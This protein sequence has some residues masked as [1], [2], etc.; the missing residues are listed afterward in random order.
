M[1]TLEDIKVT[2]II[3]TYHDWPRLQLCLDGLS[4]QTYPMSRFEIIV[5]NNDPQEKPPKPLRIPENCRIIEEKKPGSYSARNSGLKIARGEIFAFTDSDCIPDDQWI[6]TAVRY[7]EKH[8]MCDRIGGK[9]KLFSH[10]GH[11]NWIELYEILCSF[12]QENFVKFQ[13][14]AATGN[15]LCRKVV[16]DSVGVFDDSLMSGGDGEWGRRA[17]SKGFSISYLEECVVSHPTRSTFKDMKVKAK[18]LVG[19]HIALALREDKRL[20][21]KIILSCLAPPMSA[22]KLA[23]ENKDLTFL[24]K[25][26][27]VIFA[28]Y[29]KL[30][31]LPEK[32]AVA[33]FKKDVERV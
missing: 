3:P 5:I 24:E 9:I 6:E 27:A 31:V 32:I 26:K 29:L 14:M 16:F 22:I 11:P 23:H 1:I 13:G 15:M 12:P 19:G 28:Y 7:F 17:M 20:F 25:F 18:R 4:T 30:S 10:T 33:F 21:F 8:K 2:V